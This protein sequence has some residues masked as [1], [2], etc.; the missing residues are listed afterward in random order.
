MSIV[1]WST[2]R[3]RAAIG[4]TAVA[5]ALGAP[6]LL[7]QRFQFLYGTGTAVETGIHGVK[8]CASG[9]YVAV[10]ESFCCGSPHAAYVVRTNAA[11]VPIWQM[12]YKFGSADRA[13]DV[14]ELANGDFA[15]CGTTDN[16]NGCA[17]SR[18]IFIMRINSAGALVNVSTYGSPNA[19]EEAWKIVEAQVGDG[20]TT[21]RGDFIVAGSTTNGQA[22][23]S[24]DGYLLRVTSGLLLIWDAQYGGP[25]AS[26]DEYF[27][28]I[29]E[30]PA[31]IGGAGDV[32]ATGATNSWGSGGLDVF[33]VRANGNNGTIGIAPQGAAVS[34]GAF[35]DE[36]YS[37][38]VLRNGPN[39]GNIVVT[40][41]TKAPAPPSIADEVLMLEL[42]AN[43]CIQVADLAF[44]DFS[45]TLDRGYDL[46]EDAN[47]QPA[48]NSQVIV[49]GFTN[50]GNLGGENVFLQRVNT[51]CGL[52]L[53]G[54][55]MVYGGIRNDEGWSV[56]NATHNNAATRETPGYVVNGFTQSPNL[57][58]PGDPQ[59]LYVIKTD[60][61]LSSGC[62]EAPVNFNFA[63][64]VFT[65]TCVGPIV[66][67]IG[68]L[69][70]PA[71][72][73]GQINGATQICYAY[74]RAQQRGGG[75]NDGAADA[76]T[77]PTI[78]VDDESVTSYPNPLRAGSTLNIRFDLKRA[79]TAHLAVSDVAGQIVYE[80]DVDVTGG[81]AVHMLN[82]SGWP[83]GAYI[84]HVTSGSMSTTSRIV[85]ADR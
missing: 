41:R 47:P 15:V 84:V 82:T 53:A 9:G 39:T 74:P 20:I 43:P 29:D 67:S 34:G 58:P 44:G 8:Q 38:V 48:A 12:V 40:G 50:L 72:S 2:R 61:N 17:P 5:F 81:S 35:D 6:Q 65:T 56:D 25:S 75:G 42:N 19:D 70:I 73:V 60:V 77:P 11:G 85:V 54:A 63:T 36:G 27:Y 7:A 59:Q 52:T 28:G 45:T 10:G 32:V 23:P 33:T 83:A 49:T 51:V 1:H 24:R 14:V 68:Q 55:G 18:D 30:V 69:C 62:A 79:T 3:L 46:K 64:N 78:T 71:N 37:V 16:P 31:A 76:G 26:R 4:V 21:N 66:G 13:T 57:L 80:G 22:A